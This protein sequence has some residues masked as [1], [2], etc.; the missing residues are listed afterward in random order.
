MN[1]E[2]NSDLDHIEDKDKLRAEVARLREAVV[3]L[4]T[5]YRDDMRYPPA[6]DSRTRRIE[7][8]DRIIS[9]AAGRV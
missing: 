9:Q 4:A 7:M 2:S 6:A 1:L 5:Q 8:I 3:T